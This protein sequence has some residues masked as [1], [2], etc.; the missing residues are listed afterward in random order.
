MERKELVM[1]LIKEYFGRG[2]KYANLQRKVNWKPT[3]HISTLAVHG[4]RIGR[5]LNVAIKHRFKVTGQTMANPAILGWK[6]QSGSANV[7][8]ISYC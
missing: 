7:V 3:D 8:F 4:H 1:G 6:G 2:R 5:E